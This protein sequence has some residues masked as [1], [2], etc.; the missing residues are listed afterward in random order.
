MKYTGKKKKSHLESL[1][2]W[3]YLDA[4]NSNCFIA[5]FLGGEAG[6][7]KKKVNSIFSLKIQLGATAT[8]LQNTRDNT[9]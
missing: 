7:I 1:K 3:N 4:A 6:V 8:Y 5:V 2:H 9:L